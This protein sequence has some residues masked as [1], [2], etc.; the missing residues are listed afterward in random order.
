[1][2]KQVSSMPTVMYQGNIYKLRSR[3]IEVPDLDA[4]D[5]L[6]ALVWLNRNTIAKGY[7][8]EPALVLA[9]N[10]TISTK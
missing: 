3:K 10:I 2:R 6:S 8:K 1:V 9:N 4:M 7:K 5:S